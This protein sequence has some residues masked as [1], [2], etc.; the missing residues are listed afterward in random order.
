[1]KTVIKWDVKSAKR[2][3][4][5]TEGVNDVTRE[6]RKTEST[7]RAVVRCQQRCILLMKM[8][9]FIILII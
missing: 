6:I 9:Q 2:R 4:V 8:I 7:K 3:I 1:M 5:S